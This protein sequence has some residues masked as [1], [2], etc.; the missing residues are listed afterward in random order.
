MENRKQD[1]DFPLVLEEA[2]MVQFIKPIFEEDF[3]EAG[4]RAWLVSIEKEHETYK[5]HFNF[6]AFEAENDKY[7]IESFYS[8]ADPNKRNLVDAKTAGQYTPRYSV[9][10][11]TDDGG[12]NPEIFSENLSQYI[13]RI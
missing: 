3:V 7:F 13:K 5:L 1:L 10:F 6:R 8:F 2:I 9:Y 12:T 11:C 4:M